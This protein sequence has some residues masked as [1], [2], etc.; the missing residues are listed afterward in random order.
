MYEH[1]DR[2]TR[3]AFVWSLP[4]GG[5][6]GTLARRYRAGDARGNV[7][8]KTGYISGVRT[9]SGYVT[10]ERGHTIAFSLLCNDYRTRTSRVNRAQDAVVELL[11]DYVGL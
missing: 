10:S 9:L 8:A 5:E 1:P 6:T 11:A 4:L 2:A 3:D 7:R